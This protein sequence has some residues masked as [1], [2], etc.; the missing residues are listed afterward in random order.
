MCIFIVIV[1]LLLI[2]MTLK[3]NPN[4]ILAAITDHEIQ[5]PTYDEVAENHQDSSSSHADK[6]YFFDR[7]PQAKLILYG[8]ISKCLASKHKLWATERSNHSVKGA[9]GISQ[10]SNSGQLK[11][12]IIL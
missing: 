7:N 5:C 9:L 3:S 10:F 6:A 1:V 11:G 2:R 4:S 8:C 12:L